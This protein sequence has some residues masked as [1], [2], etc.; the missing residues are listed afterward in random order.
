MKTSI[1]LAATTLLAT[2]A[3]VYAGDKQ[4]NS[5]PESGHSEQMKISPEMQKR[6]Q[7]MRAE[8]MAI[9]NETDPTKRQKMMQA[10]MEKMQ[11]MMDSMAKKN[12]PGVKGHPGGMGMMMSPEMQKRMKMMQADM[13]AIRNE[14]NP[15]KRQAL[16]EA[17]MKKMQKMMKSMPM[18]G[19]QD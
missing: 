1:L 11:K 2:S 19:Q 10:H 14:T 9:Q 3:L 17:H 15:E 5:Q 12:Q 7:A 8:L 13:M 18:N 4:N 16:M 6:R